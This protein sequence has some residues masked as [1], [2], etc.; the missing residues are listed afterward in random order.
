MVS[1][2]ML[3]VLGSMP[4]TALAAHYFE[5]GNG[6]L[7]CHT[8]LDAEGDQAT[9]HLVY[10]SRTLPLVRAFAGGTVPDMIGCTYCHFRPGN[11]EMKDTLSHFLNKT[12]K[13]PVGYNFN[14]STDTNGEYFS[15]ITTTTANELDCIDCH[16]PALLWDATNGYVSKVGHVAK[17]AATRT[18]NNPYMLRSV[19]VAGQYDNH[20]RGCHGASAPTIKGKNVRVTSH[21]D[22]LATA[23]TEKDGTNLVTTAGG[24]QS[25]CNACHDTHYSAKVKL[26]NDG[27]ETGE[28]AKVVNST[29][30]TTLCHYSGDLNNGYVNHG[31]GR[32]ASTYKYKAGKVDATGYNSTMNMA[33]TSCHVP[34][35][36]SDTSTTRKKHA[37]IPTGGSM[38]DNYKA[39]FDLNLP[40]QSW[41]TGTIF[42]NPSVGVCYSCHSAYEPHMTTAG[43]VGCMDCHDEHAENSGVGSNFFMIP[44]NP[45]KVGS[46]TTATK[47]KA[48]T[49][50]VTYDTTRL[51]TTTNPYVA[52]AGADMY[53]A[54][55]Q[56]SCDV[57]ECHTIAG[58]TPLA[59]FMTNGSHS[60]G[61]QPLNADCEGCHAHNGDSSGGWRATDSCANT[62]AGCH[63]TDAGEAQPN[64]SAYPDRAGK[65][66][67]H[68]AAIAAANGLTTAGTGTCDWCHP[69]GAHSGD[70]AASPADLMNGGT[71]HFKAIKGAVDGGETVTQAGAN[72]TCAGVN[73]HY[74]NAMP[75]ADWYGT[76]S[77]SCSYCHADGVATYTAGQ[78]PNA[79]NQHVDEV[80]D[81]GYDFACTLCHPSS[82]YTQ[83]HQSGTVAVSFAGVWGT[84]G[85]EATTGGNGQVKY[86]TGTAASYYGCAGISCHGDYIG[87]NSANTP[88]WYN[89]DAVL[90]TNNGDGNCGS[91][92]GTDATKNAMP[93]YTD[94]TPKANKHSA[95]K[96]DLGF[97]CQLCHYS[98]TTDGSTVTGRANH[99]NSTTWT[100]AANTGA[101]ALY[102]F[103]WTFPNCTST[104]CHGGNTIAWNAAANS[105]SCQT[106]HSYVNGAVTNVDVNDFAWAGGTPT[107][108]KIAYTEYTA[109]SGGHGSAT[110]RAIS[111]ACNTSSCHDNTTVHDTSANLTG[112]N[113]FRLLDQSG[114]AGVQFD[115]AYTGT[116]CHVAGI[117]GPQTN[118]LLTS[119]KTHSKAVMSAAGGTPKRTWPA[120]TPQCT[121]CHDP[122]GDAN[123]SMVSRW[124]YDKAAFNLPA[125]ASAAPYTGALP[126][127]NTAI[128]FTDS[129]TGASST[130]TSYADMDTPF[131]S[132][133]QEC[134]EATDIVSFKDGSSAAG[135]NHP[136]SGTNPGD[137]TNCH[138]HDEGFNWAGNCDSC[139][140]YPPTDASGH[141]GGVVV[142]HDLARQDGGAYLIAQHNGC[143]YCHGT[144][145]S[146]DMKTMTIMPTSVLAGA[147]TYVE[148][149][150]HQKGSIEM[151]GNSATMS[152]SYNAANG[153]CDTGVCHVNDP[154]HR[155]T[156]GNTV[157]LLQLGPG[158]CQSCH[159]TGTGGA[160]VVPF[161][162]AGKHVNPTANS[163]P[164]V[165][166]C[167]ACHAGHSNGSA[168]SNNHVEIETRQATA[169]TVAVP[170][171]NE[172][173]ASH[174]YAINLGGTATSAYAKSTEA[175]LCWSCHYDL[176]TALGSSMNEYGVNNSTNTGSMV[177]NYGSLSSWNTTDKGGW[178]LA[179]GTTAANWSSGTPRFTYKTAPIAS[180]H[181]ANY[182]ATVPGNDAVGTIRCS[183]CHDVHDTGALPNGTPYLRGTWIGNPFKEDGAPQSGQAF[184][185]S[186]SWGAVPRGSTAQTQSFGGYWIDQNSATPQST[187]SYAT[188]A[189]LCATCHGSS[190]DT[191]NMFGV[192]TGGSHTEWVSGYNGHKNSVRG[193]AGIGTGTETVARNIFNKRG[194][195][196]G[197]TRQYDGMQHF[198][199][200]TAPG[201]GGTSGFRASQSA[202]Y[203]PTAGTC[204]TKYNS[205]EWNV[206]EN[207]ISAQANYH[208]FPCSKCHMPHASRLPRLML[209]NCLD[210]RHNGWDDNYQISAFG[211]VNA[212]RSLSNWTTAQ[213]CHR[214]GGTM[215][216]RTGER[217]GVVGGWNNVTPW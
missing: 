80:A 41:D 184:S 142:D 183:Y 147:A 211:T 112:A 109:A 60:G 69:G 87:G 199:G 134:H 53:G 82:G 90:G 85:D 14:S 133:C 45:K 97:G 9:K 197:T 162:V 155:L 105:I 151:N 207:G 141:Q 170:T 72:V 101:A 62:A 92:H 1:L 217:P 174:S 63:G 198:N 114:T 40:M 75:A 138:A 21:G 37:E 179:N 71:T 165:E 163:A 91:C 204:P 20:C 59:N 108:S 86:G 96:V 203:Q 132:I 70:Q 35:D 115:C 150:H 24:G 189:G 10:S 139:H 173:Y 25:Q 148:A 43:G 26:F 200:Q 192:T 171:M 84:D 122:H 130:G 6:C 182:A 136:S 156:R 143:W 78:L 44:L 120:W 169:Y 36:T 137:C 196:T 164:T 47:T 215:G 206:D 181:G 175:Q 123:L 104:Q 188:N 172:Q 187:W 66:S 68:I 153:G 159:Q 177:Y 54:S 113:P 127:E 154:A 160:P 111:K 2:L 8:V 145:E 56:G 77:G 117:S 58:R 102:Q 12:S 103:T 135:S 50:L 193:G 46:Y 19:T 185:N 167:K 79:H 55:G 30:C 152:A 210:T 48:G 95:H 126:V 216:T 5:E 81:G 65:H 34:L 83:A 67:V 33:C 106:C 146:G 100:L 93:A 178:Y 32:S 168:D 116:G 31:H 125:G 121:N 42:G 52:N 64:G 157:N 57:A 194:G 214:R 89:T 11:S 202:N 124:A 7:S 186:N 209:T 49:E 18:P 51:N 119:I 128:V 73:C 17:T 13:H 161:N 110:P 129:T 140:G 61:T 195:T 3:A 15:A 28:A 88:N 4:G 208:K 23:I 190:V 99:A 144:K 118:K 98:V 201:S 205:D 149:T 107:M 22:A 76:P 180:M 166:M 213:N 27:K 38:Q 16:D 39:K 131:S 191:L 74:N 29:D 212:S 94:G 158:Q 176:T